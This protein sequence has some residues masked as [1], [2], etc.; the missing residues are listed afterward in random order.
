[1]QSK[2]G[3]SGNPITFT[4]YQDEVVELNGTEEITS[5]WTQHSGNIYKTTLSADIWQLFVDDDMM[6][7]ARWPNATAWD[8]FWDN[9]VYWGHG[10]SSDSDGTQYDNPHDSVDL[11][12]EGKSF[13]GGMAVLNVG[14]WK[15]WAR[16]INSHTSGSNHFTY[17][18]IG[19]GYKTQWETHR[20]FLECKLNM[21]DAEK[22]WF[23]DDGTNVLYLWAPGGGSPS[24][25]IEGKTLSYAFDVDDCDYIVIDGL[26]FFA[27]TFKFS[28]SSQITV[29]NC[30]LLYPS[31]SK[32]ML[33]DT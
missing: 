22:E 3:T 7:S 25:T 30:D 20:Y 33:G 4:N 10:T 11:A 24:G 5:S 12:G 28:E 26:D 8:G 31:Y 32:R 14:N 15:S 6:I 17:D 13:A 16:V 21:L 18:A 27:T 19:G 9:T 29:E 2:N 1:M 23:Y